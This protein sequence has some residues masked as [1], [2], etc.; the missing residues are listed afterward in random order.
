MFRAGAAVSTI[1]GKLTDTS[2]HHSEGNAV[3][4]DIVFENRGFLEY[5]VVP[6]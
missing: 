2:D 5:R 1:P 6:A 4:I 3:D